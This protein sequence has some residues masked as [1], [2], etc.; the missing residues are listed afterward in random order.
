VPGGFTVRPLGATV[1]GP[2]VQ[3]GDGDERPDPLSLDSTTLLRRAQAGDG[4]AFNLLLQRYMPALRRWAHGRLPS[5]A[6]DLL[7]TDDLVQVTMTRALGHVESFEPRHAGA[8]LAYLRQILM[9]RI[10]DEIRRVLRH[11]DRDQLNDDI[12]DGGPTP[13][14]QLLG[15]DTRQRYER[16]LLKLT[17]EQREAVFLRIELGLSYEEM[18]EALVRPS[19]NAARLLVSRALV[20]LARE[21]RD[22]DP[23]R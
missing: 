14:D 10:R 7:D 1:H 22:T 19:A 17:A 4:F 3:G 6:R 21:M 9:N 8:F 2:E 13:L 12:A 23:G 16:S 11:P 20:R 18:A 5:R 15:R